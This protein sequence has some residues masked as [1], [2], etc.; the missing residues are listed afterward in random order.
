M[1][2]YALFT[3]HNGERFYF[4][5]G[6]ENVLVVRAETENDAWNLFYSCIEEEYHSEIKENYEIEMFNSRHDMDFSYYVEC[7]NKYPYI[8]KSKRSL[9]YGFKLVENPNK[10]FEFRYN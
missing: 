5:D 6:V 1:K 7:S 4:D 9:E 10:K 8:S 2:Y 3:I